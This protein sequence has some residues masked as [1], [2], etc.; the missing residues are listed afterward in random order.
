V[1]GQDGYHSGRLH[2]MGGRSDFNRIYSLLLDK[3]NF[4]IIAQ[5]LSRLGRTS[6]EKQV[7]GIII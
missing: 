1:A 5:T 7:D 2:P 6:L 4:S 3:I